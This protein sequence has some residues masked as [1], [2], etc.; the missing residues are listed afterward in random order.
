MHGDKP[1]L[2]AQNCILTFTIQFTFPV[3]SSDLVTTPS[4]L[5]VFCSIVLKLTLCARAHNT[6]LTLEAGSAEETVV[7]LGALLL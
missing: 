6:E 4:V 7:L 5:F 1:R 2:T 3:S